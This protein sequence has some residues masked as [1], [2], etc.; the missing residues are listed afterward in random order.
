MVAGRQSGNVGGR[1]SKRTGGMNRLSVNT[2]YHCCRY[3]T[4]FDVFLGLAKTLVCSL[5][6][7][8]PEI[9]LVVACEHVSPSTHLT[10]RL[11]V[12]TFGRD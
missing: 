11:L 6:C 8:E 3:D 7:N 5:D 4:W 10:R 12:E 2:L 1:W 9:V